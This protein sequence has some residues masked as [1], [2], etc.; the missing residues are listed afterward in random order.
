MNARFDALKNLFFMLYY[1]DDDKSG[2]IN[3]IAQSGKKGVELLAGEILE[4]GF[5]YAENS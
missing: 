1:K 4:K 2:S 3:R 5:S